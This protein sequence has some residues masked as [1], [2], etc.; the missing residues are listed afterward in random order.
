MENAP[1][2]RFS[3]ANV[4]VAEDN[5]FGREIIKHM[6]NYF[7]IQPEIVEDG[8]QVFSEVEKKEYDLIILDIHMPKMTGIDVAKLI[9]SKPIRQ[10]L[11]VALTASAFAHEKQEAMDAGFDDYVY[12]PVEL[13]DIEELLKKYLSHKLASSTTN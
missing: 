9:R 13:K 2:V 11:L 6:L 7:G 4:L 10:P 1:S 5:H 8:E 12:K 3:G